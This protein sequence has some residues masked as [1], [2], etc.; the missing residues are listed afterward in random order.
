[1]ILRWWLERLGLHW[2]VDEAGERPAM[3]HIVGPPQAAGPAAARTA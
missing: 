3:A 1:V 2:D